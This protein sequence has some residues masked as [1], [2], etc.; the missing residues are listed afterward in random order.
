MVVIN[1]LL[2]YD[3]EFIDDITLKII[4]LCLN[5]YALRMIEYDLIRTAIR[6]NFA[7]I[8]AL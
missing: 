1:D 3:M 8:Y 4:I 5:G 2:L 6:G 7:V